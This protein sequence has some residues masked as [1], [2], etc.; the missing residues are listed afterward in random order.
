MT[1]ASD[2]IQRYLSTG[3]AS[4]YT[5]MNRKTLNKMFDDGLLNGDKTPGGHRRFDKDSIDEYFNG[6]KKAVEMVKSLGL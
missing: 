6:N 4:K 3:E 1:H 2:I 5:G